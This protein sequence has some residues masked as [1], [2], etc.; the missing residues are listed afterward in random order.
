MDKKELL[1]IQ[2]SSST[3]LKGFL[4]CFVLGSWSGHKGLTCMPS[5]SA[6]WGNHQEQPTKKLN[7]QSKL[8]K[9]PCKQTWSALAIDE[10]MISCSSLCCKGNA[11]K[12]QGLFIR[13]LMSQIFSWI[14]YPS[15]RNFWRVPSMS[16]RPYKENLPLFAETHDVISQLSLFDS[17]YKMTSLSFQNIRANEECWEG[18]QVDPSLDL[19]HWD[20]PST[21]HKASS[22]SP[23]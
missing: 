14:V 23:K 17:S 20:W 18:S 22:L 5:L 21:V 9:P 7:K 15:S 10:N 4:S 13:Y 3:Y 6:L 16:K 2:T 12:N 11:I 19:E 1:T 8:T